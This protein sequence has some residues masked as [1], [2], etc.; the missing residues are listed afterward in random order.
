[1]QD[2]PQATA[3][4]AI[5]LPGAP[6]GSKELNVIL[7]REQVKVSLRLEMIDFT[8]PAPEAKK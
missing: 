4:S 3:E 2:N 6:E 8:V 1:V 7:G 5:G